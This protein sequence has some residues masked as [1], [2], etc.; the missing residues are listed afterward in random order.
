MPRA[1]RMLLAS[2]GSGHPRPKQ[3]ALLNTVEYY[4]APGSVSR[5]PA[6]ASVVLN[7]PGMGT[8]ETAVDTQRPVSGSDSLPVLRLEHEACAVMRQ[9]VGDN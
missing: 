3:E 6:A 4:Q 2:V 1:K 5:G 7:I 8:A 9:V